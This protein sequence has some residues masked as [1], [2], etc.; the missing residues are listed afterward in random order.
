MIWT[1]IY[2]SRSNFR[3]NNFHPKHQSFQQQDHHSFQNTYCKMLFGMNALSL[4]L[5]EKIK[6]GDIVNHM[7]GVSLHDETAKS[8]KKFYSGITLAINVGFQYHMQ[9]L[10][11]F[12]ELDQEID[13]Q[14]FFF[15]TIRGAEGFSRVKMFTFNLVTFSKLDLNNL[16]VLLNQSVQKY[17]KYSVAL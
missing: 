14:E 10:L 7:R 13:S 5:N 17:I 11:S 16:P 1:T 9:F 2:N 8:I 15:E 12:D 3:H 6:F 4:T